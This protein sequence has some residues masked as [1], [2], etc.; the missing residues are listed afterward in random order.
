MIISHHISSNHLPQSFRCLHALCSMFTF[1]CHKPA[2]S[3]QYVYLHMSEACML[4]TVCL[5]SYVRSLH[6]TCSMFTFMSEACMLHTECLPY[7]RSLHALCSMIIFIC[8]KH[9]CS[10][11]Y[12]YLHMSEACMLHTECLPSYVRNRHALCSMITLH[13]SL[14]FENNHHH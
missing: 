10:M 3:M 11:Q 5:P 7:V 14:W 12:D 4:H 1:I 9:A 2:C 8:Q 6:A 13:I